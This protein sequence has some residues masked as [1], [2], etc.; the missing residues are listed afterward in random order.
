MTMRGMSVRSLVGAGAVLAVLLAGVPA[1]QAGWIWTPES[2]RWVN[3]TNQPK[4]TASLQFQYA[5]ELL[6]REEYDDA[7]R[8]FKRIHSHFTASKYADLAQF[9]IGRAH[10]AAG[11]W[12]EAAEAY[13][14][15]IDR[16]PGTRL[17]DRVIT[18]QYELGNKYYQRAL[19]REEQRRLL[20]NWREVFGAEDDFAR[21]IDVYQRVVDN[22]PFTDAAAE[23]QY[24]IGLCHGKKDEYQEAFEAFQ[25]VVDLY[26]GSPWAAEAAFGAADAQF[27]QILPAVYDQT[28]VDEAM[29]MFQFYLRNYQAG[30]RRDEIEGMMRQLQHR[31]AEHEFRIGEWYH[32]NY[33][34]ESARL[35]YNQVVKAFPK[36]EWAD[37]SREQL[38]LLP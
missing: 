10:E 34:F 30:A 3:P 25:G 35:Y 8:E 36:T 5:E 16:Y 19:E 20:P 33:K 27:T 21:A 1:A 4:E 24:R 28:A 38:G 11:R 6:Q 17:F 13:Q 37:R 15:T 32:K 26:P 22:Q 31:R 29:E 7:I 9:S 2:G 14:Q 18:K 23:A 12:D